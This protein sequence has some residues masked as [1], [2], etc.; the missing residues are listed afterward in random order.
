ML[1]RAAFCKLAA[2]VSSALRDPGSGAGGCPAARVGVPVGTGQVPVPRMAQRGCLHLTVQ[3]R[4]LNSPVPCTSTQIAQKQ[5]G[6]RRC[7]PSTWPCA[8]MV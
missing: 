5:V 2:E 1:C 3:W 4:P 8:M 6:H 7:S